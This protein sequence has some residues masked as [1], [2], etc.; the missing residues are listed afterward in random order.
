VE[1]FYRSG[2]IVFAVFQLRTSLDRY[3]FRI[4]Q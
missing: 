4:D 3:V 1:L 2:Q